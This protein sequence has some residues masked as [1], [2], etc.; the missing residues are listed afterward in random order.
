MSRLNYMHFVLFSVKP[1]FV[2]NITTIYM[3]IHAL[4]MHRKSAVRSKAVVR[5]FRLVIICFPFEI[6]FQTILNDNNS[7]Y[8]NHPKIIN[9]RLAIGCKLLLYYFNS[10]CCSK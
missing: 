2:I 1:S 7:A 10:V 3:Y 4:P 9:S 5:A 6:N 8:H